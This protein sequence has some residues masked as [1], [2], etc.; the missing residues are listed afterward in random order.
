MLVM[1]THLAVVGHLR[2]SSHL[3]TM[4]RL[5]HLLSSMTHLTLVVSNSVH[6]AQSL[7]VSCVGCSCSSALRL[8]PLLSFHGLLL[9]LEVLL[10]LLLVLVEHVADLAKMVD[11]RVARVELVVLVGA[12]DRLVPSLLLSLR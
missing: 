5:P 8:S 9:G 6:S 11:L 7:L 3:T 4:S 1:G 10:S 12:L 2:M